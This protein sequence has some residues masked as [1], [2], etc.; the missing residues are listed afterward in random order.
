MFHPLGSLFTQPH[1]LQWNDVDVRYYIQ[2][3]LRQHVRSESVYCDVFH[4]GVAEVRVGS[5]ALQ[6]VA[7]LCEYDL[8]QSL[9]VATGRTLIKLKV[10]R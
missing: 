7:Q 8:A 10:K 9:Q 3:F 5:S 1:N 2:D 6:Q 4:E